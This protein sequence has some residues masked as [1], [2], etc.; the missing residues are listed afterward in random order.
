M[1]YGTS[2]SRGLIGAIAASLHHSHSSMGPSRV[3]DL[4]RSSQQCQILNPM[5]EARYWTLI[6]IDTNWVQFHWATTGTSVFHSFAGFFPPINTVLS[7]GNVWG[8]VCFFAL[9]GRGL[10]KLL[11][12][13]YNWKNLWTVDFSSNPTLLYTVKKFTTKSKP[14][15]WN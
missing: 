11:K 1:A 9:D 12:C 7:Q 5:S 2:Q 3:C 4:H 14:E 6:L 8:W 10:I 13:I 15:I